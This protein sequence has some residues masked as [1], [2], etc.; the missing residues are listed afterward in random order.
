MPPI[1]DC[2]TLKV[3]QPQPE[4]VVLFSV[5]TLGT[6]LKDNRIVWGGESQSF[7][8]SQ[9]KSGVKISLNELGIPTLGKAD[10]SAINT[11]PVSLFLDPSLDTIAFSPRKS[12]GLLRFNVKQSKK[13]E[14]L[15][16]D[17][18]KAIG[19]FYVDLERGSVWIE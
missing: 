16:E 9:I 10:L 8:W 18:V 1:L 17:N 14:T 11:R 4:P 13:N 2:F 6:D 5:R 12:D 3:L 19:E 7:R 15:R